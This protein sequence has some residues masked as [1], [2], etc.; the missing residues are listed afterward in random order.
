MIPGRLLLLITLL[1]F[2]V[3]ADA[4]DRIRI[5][6][7]SAVLGFAQ[8]VAEQF[9]R[10]WHHPA[11]SLEVTGTGAGFELFCAGVGFEYPDV[12]AAARPMSA[13]ERAACAAQG[14]TEITDIE[15]A[16][17]AMVLIH[18]GGKPPI[19]LTRAQLFAALGARVASQGRLTNNTAKRWSDVDPALPASEILVMAPEPNTSA[20][21]AFQELVLAEGCRAHPL[22]DRLEDVERERVC[23]SLRRDDHVINAAKREDRVVEWLD[24]NENGYAVVNYTTYK[25]FADKIGVNLVEAVEPSDET[26]GNKRYPLV[27]GVYLYVKDRHAGQIPGLQQF[28]FELTSERALAPDGYLIEQGLVSLDD[29]GRNRA[30]DKALRLGM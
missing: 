13:A 29:M 4:R 22:I 21:I 30:R 11:P 26:I 19:N 6:G 23:R 10:H 9:V 18:A 3:Q 1:T 2:A 25:N 12:V 24:D 16:R 27:T 20:A 28:L 14:V 15:F 7:S 8:P 5:V 17:D